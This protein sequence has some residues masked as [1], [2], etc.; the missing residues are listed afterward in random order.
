MNWWQ[1][2]LLVNL[3]LLLFYVFYAL[4]LRRETF[5]QL[6][7][8]YLISSALLS[9]FIPLI[10]AGWIQNLFITQK[11]EYTI[12]S[13]AIVI[14]NFKPVKQTPLSMGDVLTYVYLA[15]TAFLALRL[16]AQ[17]IALNEIIKLPEEGAAYSF[18]KKIKLDMAYNDNDAIATHEQVHTRQWHSADVMIMEAVMIINWFNPVVYF[19]RRAIK[20]IHEFIADSKA[21]KTTTNKSDYALLLL[22][23]TFNIP[24]HHL[25]NHFFNGSLLKQRIIMLQKNK[26]HR[27]SL[28]KY[29][30][31]APLFMLM[32]V[33][34][35]ATVNNSQAIKQVN[36]VAQAAF[37]QPAK[38]SAILKLIPLMND[39]NDTTNKV[40]TSALTPHTDTDITN[41]MSVRINSTVKGKVDSAPV[42]ALL[43]QLPGL[44]VSGNGSISAQGARVTKVRVNGLD[45]T[46]AD[47]LFSSVEVQPKCTEFN[48]F[49]VKN[50]KYPPDARE[51]KIQG[52]AIVAFIIEKDGSVSNVRLLRSPNESLGVEAVRVVSMSPKW[53]PGYQNGKAVRVQFAVPVNFTFTDNN[54][55]GLSS[56]ASTDTSGKTSTLTLK[57]ITTTIICGGWKGNKSENLSLISPDKIETVTI[58]KGR[59]AKI[60]YGE[61]GKNGVVLIT[62]KKQASE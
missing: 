10:Q 16:I 35:S 30:L 49:L 9:F 23:Q 8:I 51:Q 41:A 39:K 31:S 15:G 53:T 47:I 1:Y 57:F 3:Y 42:Q 6:N 36:F 26:S 40:K 38:P 22:T 55:S 29:G 43:K 4:L 25:V 13:N 61:K 45:M 62:S 14:H 48:D 60:Q 54:S 11:V 28:L 32:L 12:Y 37:N 58:L 17:L 56:T 18:F 46:P 52:K 27:I 24:R 50:I 44:T 19:Y 2:L 59:S 21:V 7:R 5:F 34:S 20:H 33:L